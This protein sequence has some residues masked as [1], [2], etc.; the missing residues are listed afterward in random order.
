MPSLPT[1]HAQTPLYVR[2][3]LSMNTVLNNVTTGDL[4]AV[5]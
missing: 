1:C 5:A 4:Q 2:Y 3:T